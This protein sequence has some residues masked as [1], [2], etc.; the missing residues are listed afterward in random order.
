VSSPQLVLASGSP[1]RRALIGQLGID[2]TVVVPNVDETLLPGET[3]E[4]HTERLAQDKA[5]KV[6]AEHGDQWVLA[7]DTAVVIDEKILGKPDDAD[8]AFAMLS[9]ISGRWHTV[10]TGY[11]L[12]NK[13]LDKRFSGTVASDV[14]IRSL[15][16]EQISAYVATGEPM[17]KAGAYAIQGIGAGLVQ[18][19]RGS[20]TNVVGLPLAEVAI[21][22]ERIHGLQVLVGGQS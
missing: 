13:A 2:F 21:L 7:A 18:Q 8:D 9:L 6:A 3:P 12:M 5:K 15:T 4:Q 19:V 17:D 11:C 22:W 16:P 10:F 14:F 20:Y 1:R